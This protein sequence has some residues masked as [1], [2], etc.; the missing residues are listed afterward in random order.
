MSVACLGSKLKTAGLI[1][2]DLLG[3]QVHLLGTCD[4]MLAH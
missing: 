2:D 4:G 1:R 3:D